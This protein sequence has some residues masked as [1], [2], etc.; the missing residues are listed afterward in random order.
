M[1]LMGPEVRSTGSFD[2]VAWKGINCSPSMGTA[3]NR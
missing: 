2:R 1:M 3:S